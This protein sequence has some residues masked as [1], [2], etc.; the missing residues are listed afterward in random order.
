MCSKRA[1]IP[2]W[3]SPRVH[4]GPFN[5][6]L[7]GLFVAAGVWTA[8]LLGQRHARSRGLPD[9]LLATA[10]VLALGVGLVTGHLFH[11]YVY[12]P[13][14]L[15]KSPWQPLK[16]WDGS[17]SLG[18]L[19][20]GVVAVLAYFR[21]KRIQKWDYG[22]TFALGIAPGWAIARFGCFV[23]HDHPGSLTASPLGV[24]FPAGARHD[25]GLYEAL[26]LG[27]ISAALWLL[28]PT[29]VG[30][31][32]RFDGQLIGVLALLY[33]VGRFFLDFLRAEDLAQAYVDV[34]YAGLTPGQYVAFALV[35]FGVWRLSRRPPLT[36]PTAGARAPSR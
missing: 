13:E 25:L 27:G 26:L 7:M 12:H 19:I 11:L 2:F 32:R 16:F 6:E 14:E 18:G 35:G 23:A 3:E 36:P 10:G 31:R 17:S 8:L 1:V 30:R 34:R 22:D 33:G 15:A 21:F 5:V 24:A 9:E 28:E 29:G 4:L 20:G